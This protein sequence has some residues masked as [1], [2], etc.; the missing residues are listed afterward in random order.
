MPDPIRNLFA[1]LALFNL[2]A[3]IDRGAET[4]AARGIYSMSPSK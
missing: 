2:Y 1:F 4:I 3:A